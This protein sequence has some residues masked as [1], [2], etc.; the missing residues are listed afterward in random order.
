VNQ[1]GVQDFGVA[2]DRRRAT[3][4][5]LLRLATFRSELRRFQ[6][7][8]E[9][10][11]TDAGLT[12]Q[13]YDLLLMLAAAPTDGVRVT[14]LCDLLQMRQ[15]AVTELVGRTEAA[16]LLERRPSPTDGRV[17]LLRLT[18]EGESRLMRAVD[19]LRGDREALGQT[20]HMLE[21]KLGGTD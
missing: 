10:V 7:R 14:D 15:T 5:E 8:V 12:P 1:S 6:R 16:G 19:R 11:T 17:S 21:Q 3:R 4:R 13:R 20:L 9:I 2:R 18:P